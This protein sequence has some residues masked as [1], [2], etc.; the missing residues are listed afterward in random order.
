MKYGV[1]GYKRIVNSFKSNVCAHYARVL[2]V[3]PL[4]ARLPRLV[5][6]IQ[7]TYIR[8]DSKDVRNQ[9]EKVRVLWVKHLSVVLRP[10]IGHSLLENASKLRQISWNQQRMGST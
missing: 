1:T 6:V 3:N 2:I 7:L 9:W 10:L 8:F 4:H 5:A